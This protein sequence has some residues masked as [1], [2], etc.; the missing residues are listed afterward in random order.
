MNKSS[1]LKDAVKEFKTEAYNG[2][3]AKV[4]HEDYTGTTVQF[5]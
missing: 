2:L 3:F 5:H 1:D 4:K